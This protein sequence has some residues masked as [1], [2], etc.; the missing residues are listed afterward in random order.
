MHNPTR[1]RSLARRP[2]DNER[3]VALA[4]AIFAIVIIGMLVAGVFYASFLEQRTGENTLYAQ[5]AFE[6]AEGGMAAVM[7]NWDQAAYGV[8]PV[9]TPQVLTAVTVGR[10]R[11]TPIITRLNSQLFLVAARGE[12]FDGGGAVLSRRMLGTL[13]RLAPVD[14]DVK[15]AVTAKGQVKVG[16]NSTVNGNDGVPDGWG[17]ACPPPGPAKA[18]VRTDQVVQV[19]GAATTLGSPPNQEHDAGVVD[20][21]FANPF[22][23]LKAVATITLSNLSNNGMAP[24]TTGTPVRCNKALELNWGEPLYNPP[25]VGAVTQCQ[26]YFPVIYRNGDLR[27]QNGRGQGILLV[28]G[29]LEVRGNFEFAG[30]VIVRGELKSNGTGNKI[31]GGV[32]AQNADLGD[33][34]T[35]IGNPVV[36]FSSCAI[37]KA[38]AASAIVRPLTERSWAQLY[39]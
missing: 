11:Y 17:A 9:D 13:A 25:V 22:N 28:E 21:I 37:S 26:T 39:N 5:Q 10:T 2:L 7:N 34:T 24:S 29:N 31:T 14:V 38:L 6:A 4:V 32:L 20:S 1:F 33:L 3:G 36:N 19:S 12:Q 16:G 8:F 27:V 23:A 35:L 15:A 18:G 30:L